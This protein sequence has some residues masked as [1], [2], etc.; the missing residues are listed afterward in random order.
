VEFVRGRYGADPRVEIVEC[1]SNLGWSRGN[2]V[3][4]ARA[5]DAG[6]DFVFLLNND[7]A[8]APDAV[9]QLVT[10]ASGHPKAG[11]IAPKMVLFDQPWLINSVGIAC[12][13]VGSAWDEGIG[14]VDGP[15]WNEAKHV[16][17]VCGGAMFLRAD[18]LRTTGFLPEDFDIYLDDLDLCLRIWDAGHECWSCPSAVVRHKFG[19]TMGVGAQARRKHFL[20]TRNRLRLV[21]RNFPARRMPAL[22]AHFFIS[23]LRAA[24]RAALDGAWWK[25][26]AHAR[27][28]CDP[29]T[30]VPKAMAHR[31]AMRARGLTIGNSWPF[32][33][34]DRY[35]FA[36]VELPERGWYAP[37]DVHGV[38]LRPISARA[39]ADVPGGGLSVTH[40]N[41]YPHLGAS[42]VE[43]W[44]EGRLLATLTSEGAPR[45]ERFAVNAGTVELTARRI[46]DAETTGGP[47]DIGGWI[48]LAT[49]GQ[50]QTD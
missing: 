39:I 38:S 36:G 32:I 41:C 12:S 42:C 30:Y 24:G 21:L 26:A 1:G 31:R 22:L 6:A 5:L 33:R 7:T 9:E 20:A 37:M 47:Y 28:W 43:L 2:N 17:G 16:L 25:L 35:F 13:S 23:E 14:R 15:R 48:A 3:G 44:Q 4:I 11:A 10:C 46:F 49:R 19:A 50:G 29:V 34:A 8:T 40:A 18:A 45:T 27:S